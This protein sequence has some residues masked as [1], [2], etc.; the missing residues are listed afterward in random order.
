MVAILAFNVIFFIWGA[1]LLVKGDFSLM[2]LVMTSVNAISLI[3]NA[4][5][6]LK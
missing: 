4:E 2:V 3:L 6:I 1:L 5:K